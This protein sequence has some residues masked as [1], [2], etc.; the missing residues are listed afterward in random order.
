MSNDT[1]LSNVSSYFFISGFVISKIKYLPIAVVSSALNL[2]SLL[3]Y[4]VGYSLWFIASHFYP[5]HDKRKQEWYEFAQFKEQYLYAAALGLVA[6]II[7]MMAVFSPIM[8]VLSGW[9]FFGSN[10]IWTI[11]EYNKLNNP[12][13]YEDNFSKDSQNAYVSYAL[14]MSLIGFI[15]ATSTTV[16]FFIPVMTIPLL[17][18]TTILCI[19][20]GALAFEYW[21]E[22][23][24][25]DSQPDITIDESYKQI[26]NTLGKKINLKPNPIPEPY[27]GTKPLHSR[28]HNVKI[29]GPSPDLEIDLSSHAC[30]LQH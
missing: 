3:F 30:K 27:H 28:Q 17:I 25:G 2:I 7:S 18:I 5:G 29:Q 24:F 4:L 14:S 1:K 21:L 8:I 16:A 12:P 11:G 22:S 13:S 15:T 10:I 19:G 23:K 6:T 9:L 20:V 26:S